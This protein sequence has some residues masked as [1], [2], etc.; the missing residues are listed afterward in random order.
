MKP[1][2]TVY[3]ELVNQDN[4]GPRHVIFAPRDK[5]QVRNFRKEVERQNRLSHDA[6]FNT[7]HLCY[8][9]KMNNRKA[10][11]QDFI[12]SLS[13][14]PNVIVHMIA[15]PLIEG[16]EIVLKMST[17][18]IMLH[19]DTVFNMGD[20]YLS[21]LLFK[22]SMFKSHPVV[23]FGFLV[24]TRRFLK[25]HVRFMEVIRQSSPFLTSKKIIIVTDREFNF[26][27]LFPL[28]QHVF[29]WNHL[30]QDLHHY[31]KQ[32]ANCNAAEISYF[33]NVLK[34]LMQETTEI[35]FDR[36]WC[37]FKDKD[38]FQTN[39]VVRNYFETNLLPV[40]II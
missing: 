22:H 29:C 11:P 20:F 24:H 4:G 37:D 17:E 28:A 21:T 3:Q 2:R 34:Q 9:L 35:D 31:L 32:K 13:V 18:P 27:S 12:R 33:A 19:Y 39:T 38:P 8:Q 10:E 6:M 25:D 23:P 40:F 16:L 5:N 15:Q 1:H 14:Y 36:S 7:Y 30:E 26:S